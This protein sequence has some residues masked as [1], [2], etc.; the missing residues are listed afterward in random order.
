MEIES[1]YSKEP[2]EWLQDLAEILAEGIANLLEDPSLTEDEV[3]MP[4]V[5]RRNQ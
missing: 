4:H 1:T 2:P 3:P 5:R